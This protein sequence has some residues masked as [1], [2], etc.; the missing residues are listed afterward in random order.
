MDARAP[1]WGPGST[2]PSGFSR[3]DKNFRPR[4]HARRVHLHVTRRANLVTVAVV[5]LDRAVVDFT[6]EPV[7]ELDLTGLT[8]PLSAFVN[9]LVS[10]G[11]VDPELVLE[12]A[13]AAHEGIEFADLDTEVQTFVG[14]LID[15]GWCVPIATRMWRPR[16]RGS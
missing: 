5:A 2:Q 12:A 9:A 14:L 16:R 3:I 11:L 7:V 1:A 6:V 4:S 10:R 8:S 15:V 13:R